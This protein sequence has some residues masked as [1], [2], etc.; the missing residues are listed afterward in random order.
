MGERRTW[1]PHPLRIMGYSLSP[2]R[3]LENRTL[4]VLEAVIAFWLESSGGFWMSGMCVCV[5]A[6]VSGA[7]PVA[8]SPSHAK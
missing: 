7:W 3:I 8:Q 2:A 6:L 5:C 1:A 4:A